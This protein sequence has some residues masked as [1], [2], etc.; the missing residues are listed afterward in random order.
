MSLSFGGFQVKQGIPLFDGSYSV[1]LDI[2][3][4]R[5]DS[6]EWGSRGVECV[7]PRFVFRAS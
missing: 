1:T 6:V 5:V 3:Y 2:R 4:L 7:R